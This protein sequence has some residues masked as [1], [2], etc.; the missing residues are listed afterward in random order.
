[1][2]LMLLI[3]GILGIA[4]VW[5]LDCKYEQ[6]GNNDID[7]EMFQNEIIQQQVKM[8]HLAERISQDMVLNP[9]MMWQNIL[10][11]S[12]NEPYIWLIYE[13]DFLI[14]WSSHHLPY[15]D[16]LYKQLE[17]PIIHLSNGWYFVVKH[18]T[19][20]YHVFSLLPVKYDYPYQN[21]YIKNN[22]SKCFDMVHAGVDISLN[23][24]KGGHAVTGVNGNVLFYLYKKYPGQTGQYIAGLSLLVLC[25]S[26]ILFFV[27][28][29]SYFNCC[30]SSWGLVITGVLLGVFYYLF[31]VSGLYLSVTAFELFSPVYFAFSQ[32]LSSIGS[33][34]VLSVFIFYYSFIILL[35]FVKRNYNYKQIS[36]FFF[37]IVVLVLTLYFFVIHNLFVIITKHSPDFSFISNVIEIDK[38]TISKLVII[39]LLFSSYLF[40]FD[41]FIIRLGSSVGSKYKILIISIVLFFAVIFDLLFFDAKSLIGLTL[42]EVVSL[43]FIFFKDKQR[44]EFSYRDVIWMVLIFDLFI[45]AESFFLN[46]EKEK[47]SRLFLIENLANN[48]E[49]EQDPVAEMFFSSIEKNIILDPNIKDMILNDAIYDEDIRQ[50]FIKNYF[51]GYL[52]RYDVQVVPCWPNAELYVDGGNE[53]FDCYNYFDSLLVRS[54]EIVYGS[55]NFYFIRRNNGRVNYFGM[56]TF[57]EDDPELET[58]LYLE[59]ISKPYFEGLGYPE[60]L[61]S[62]KEKSKLDLL[63]GY[64]YAKYVN[65]SLVKKS[66]DYLYKV[67]NTDFY[68]DSINHKDFIKLND[69]SHLIYSPKVNEEIVMS[70]PLVSFSNVLISFSIFFIV[71]ILLSIVVV[72]VP[73]IYSKNFFYATT[74][75]DRIRAL[76]IIFLVFLLIVIGF[77]SVYYSINQFKRKN[78]DMLS[79]RLK[80]VMLQLDQKIG[81]EDRLTEDMS[82]YLNF[83]LQSFSN[84]FYSDINLYNLNGEV[85]ATSRPELYN[86]GIVGNLMNPNAYQK[87][88]V[89]GE[90]ELIHDESIGE[91]DYISAYVPFVNQNN[92]VLAYLNL[93][94]FV[95]THELKNEISS[96]LV[97]IINAYL[98]FMLIAVSLVVFASRQVTRPLFI[99][100]ERLSQT[101]LG[102]KN[103]K[104]EYH[105]KDEIGQLVKEYNRMIDELADSAEKLA[106]S[107][108]EGAW[109]EMAKQIAHEIKNPLTPMKLSIQ[110]LQKAWDDKVDDFD[111]F[112]KRVTNTLTD[113]INQLSVIA[114]EFSHFAKMP[115]ANRQPIDIVSKL[116]NTVSLY[117]KLSNI[118]FFVENE[119]AEQVIVLF[120]GEQILSVFNNL[121]KNAVQSI[122]RGRNGIV[123]IGIKENHDD[124]VLSFS[125]NGKGIEASVQEKMFMPNFTTKN[126]GMGLGLAI[127]KNII[128]GSNGKI[129]FETVENEGSTFYIS[130]PKYKV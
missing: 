76:M 28:G 96:V 117:E 11:V 17:Q 35:V 86:R 18:D 108:R 8:E 57:F 32:W 114:N 5:F 87:L 12:R 49:G 27:A 25:V 23:R 34:L 64:S 20:D 24:V 10:E 93:P 58:K 105:R 83:L 81:S 1:M 126:S 82:E 116:I 42:L 97:A 68:S 41:I 26:F 39:F 128:E 85:L 65:G 47:E 124:V 44:F 38:I 2:F 91:L 62:Q 122:P 98:I 119:G 71:F 4:I 13:Q 106:K 84:V 15:N 22:F 90:R 56:F 46:I 16:S 123:K 19:M 107:E 79:Q 95:G 103:E 53:T 115:T 45:V 48:L 113:Q 129:W 51:V 31:F 110:Y 120:D 94:Y 112:I 66:G 37:T 40:L 36:K 59:L 67:Y 77:G 50:Y 43:Y 3:I 14:G 80:S 74:I 99:I 100:Q 9:N 72:F 7:F 89:E 73:K 30:Y 125:D 55:G 127:V 109:R 75:Q 111:S 102:L 63:K 104:I 92:E 130:L 29:F 52:N 6:A 88:V 118:H 21:Q 70:Y 54:G 33:F 121:L 78:R 61:L 60:L 101:R 69:Y